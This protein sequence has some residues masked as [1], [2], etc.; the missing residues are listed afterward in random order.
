MWQISKSYI[1]FTEKS[2]IFETSATRNPVRNFDRMIKPILTYSSDVWGVNKNVLY[3]LD[4]VFLNNVRFVLCVKLTTI[5]VLVIE[6]SG[7]FPTSLYCH[8]N[9]LFL[10]PPIENAIRKNC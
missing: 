3:E 8:I 1:W 10:S 4:K 6:E 5:N 7:K 9:V 2:E